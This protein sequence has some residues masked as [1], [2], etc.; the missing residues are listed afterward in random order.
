MTL[1]VVRPDDFVDC[2]TAYGAADPAGPA[3]DDLKRGISAEA[4]AQDDLARQFYSRALVEGPGDTR[5]LNKLA[6][7]LER[8]QQNEELSRLSLQ[9]V[10][11]QTAVEPRTLLL[12][13]NA[14]TKLGNT[15]GVVRML[16]AQIKL[17]PPSA[18]LYN[19]LANA[20]EATGNMTRAHDLRTLAAA[21]K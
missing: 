16:E 17:Q 5:S 6:E 19:A 14:L 20:S 2:W 9:P 11:T 1:R 18:P 4:Q 8:R 15:K 21:I 3:L 10:V 7:L 13:S 12:I